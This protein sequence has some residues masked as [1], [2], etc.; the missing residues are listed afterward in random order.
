MLTLIIQIAFFKIISIVRLFIT[1]ITFNQFVT[2][3]SFTFEFVT[4]DLDSVFINFL[5]KTR[6]VYN[7]KTQMRRDELESMTSMQTL[8]HQL[9]KNDWTF[10]FQKDRLNQVTHLFFAKKS[11]QSIL[12][13]NYEVLIMNCTYKINRYK[14]S[15]M[16][17]FDQIVLHKI[18][19][20]VFCFMTKKKQNDYVWILQQLIHLYQKLKLSDFTIFLTDMKR[21][22]MNDRLL[23]FSNANHLL[24]TW[25]INNNVL[26]NC[27]KSFFIK[28]AWEKFFSE[29]KT[30][31]YAESEQEYLRSWN[32]FFE[33]YNSSHDEC[34]KYLYDIYIR[35]FRRR[36]VKCYINQMLHFD[37]TVTSRDERAHA[38]LKRQLESSIENLKIV[39][40]KINLLLINE[41]HNYLIDIND[42]KLRYFI[43][44]RKHVFDQLTSFVICVVLWKIL[45][46]YKKLIERSTII[47]SC[48]RVFIIITELSCFH[49]IQKRLYETDRLLIKNVH[50]HWR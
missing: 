29:W 23:I 34:V 37:I 24:C 18:F 6:D 11:S 12:K 21:E 30:V 50:S 40:N 8:M 14:M 25:H 48:T 44:L 28:E 27:K 9:N 17:I 16:I 13:I 31:M 19:Y 20:V 15:L 49:K 38:V 10:A 3:D 46:Q 33:R 35:D 26:I 41:Q 4:V 39:M 1:L 47:S 43:E 5:I 42:A 7:I 32:E 2:Y 36:F 22:L 45:S